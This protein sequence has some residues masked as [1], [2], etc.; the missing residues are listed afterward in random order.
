M[1]EEEEENKLQV[2]HDAALIQDLFSIL[3][4]KKT[5]QRFVIKLY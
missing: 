3:L 2:S 4:R 1:E 5:T